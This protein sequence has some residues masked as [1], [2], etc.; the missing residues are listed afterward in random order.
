VGHKPG[1]RAAYHLYDLY[2]GRDAGDAEAAGVGAV[3]SPEGAPP[4]WRIR[5]RRREYDLETGGF[6]EQGEQWLVGREPDA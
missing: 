6:T 2:D 3:R 4:R 5:A 1:K